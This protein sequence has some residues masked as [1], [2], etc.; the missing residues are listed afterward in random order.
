[1]DSSARRSKQLFFE[2]NVQVC[3][4]ISPYLT[5]GP[6]VYCSPV[7]E[8]ISGLPPMKMG[9]N[10]V[11]G[12]RL[13]LEREDVERITSE[14]PDA[15]RYIRQYGGTQELLS[16]THRWCVWIEDGEVS[17]AEKIRSLREII[18][19]C[20]KYREGAG[21]DARKAAR[22]PHAFCYSTFESRDFIHVGNTIGNA[23][24]FV[25]VDLRKGGYVSNHNAF[26]VYGAHLDAFAVVVSTLHRGWCREFG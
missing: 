5:A 10:A 23:L 3:D 19:N 21:R 14:A 16:G 4:N 17:N 6:D 8:P 22:R 13:V 9:S 25:P 18:E 1:L 11:D 26:T 15:R 7:D 12:K 2:D 20:R 24:P